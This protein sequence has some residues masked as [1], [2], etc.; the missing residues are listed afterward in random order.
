MAP[1]F[2]A[3]KTADEWDQMATE[4]FRREQ[5]SWERSD[6]DG[7]L[8]QGAS[9]AMASLYRLCAE[10]ARDGGTRTFEALADLDGNLLDAREVQTRYGYA[11]LIT[12]P[13]GSTAW[14]NPSTARNGERRR[15]ANAR[16]GYKFIQFRSEAAVFMGNSWNAYAVPRNGAERII[17]G[18]APSED[19]N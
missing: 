15:A 14:F 12:N 9:V 3:E 8:S 11:W 4:R 18:D 16:K 10:I 1:Y 13:D 6:T 2:P 7:F 19:W 5:D 17:L